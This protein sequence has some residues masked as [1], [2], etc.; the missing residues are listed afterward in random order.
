M[1]IHITSGAVGA[2]LEGGSVKVRVCYDDTHKEMKARRKVE[3]SRGHE[4]REGLKVSIYMSC[5]ASDERKGSKRKARDEDSE[6]VNEYT[7]HKR[8]KSRRGLDLYF[9]L[10]QG[11]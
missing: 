2:Q 4:V 3:K 1:H 9:V 8:Y 11:V 5:W 7:G 10:N 6:R